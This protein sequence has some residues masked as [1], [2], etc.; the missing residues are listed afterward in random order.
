MQVT[1][2]YQKEGWTVQNMPDGIAGEHAADDVAAAGASV[3]LYALEPSCA[4]GAS[5][6][7]QM[8]S[9][10]RE[11]AAQRVFLLSSAEVF[12][13]G[14]VVQET[15]TAAPQTYIGRRLCHLEALAASW[16]AQERMAITVVRLPASP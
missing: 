7:E 11:H 14:R 4:D 6:L 1:T 10:A 8:L 16:R 3:I 12:P 9:L 15:D 2:C 13:C 5:R